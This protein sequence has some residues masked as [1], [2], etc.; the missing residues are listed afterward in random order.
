V[1]PSCEAKWSAMPEGTNHTPA[2]NKAIDAKARALIP[3][4]CATLSLISSILLPFPVFSPTAE[5]SGGMSM[6]EAQLP[7]QAKYRPS[8]AICWRRANQRARQ[9]FLYDAIATGINGHCAKKEL[10]S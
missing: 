1:A 9:L 7:V 3:V 8:S 5:L 2:Q 6:R 4:L 10:K